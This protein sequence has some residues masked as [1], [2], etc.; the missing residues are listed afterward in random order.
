[1]AGLNCKINVYKLAK[2]YPPLQNSALYA[3]YL[4]NNFKKILV[5]YKKVEMN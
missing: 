5:I 4:K 2:K 1:M 3:K